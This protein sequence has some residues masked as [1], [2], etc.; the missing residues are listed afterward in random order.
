MRIKLFVINHLCLILTLPCILLCFNHFLFILTF[1]LYLTMLIMDLILKEEIV[2][3]KLV[4]KK[5][6]ISIGL[7]LIYLLMNYEFN[8]I[9][10]ISILCLSHLFLTFPF[11]KKPFF[12]NNNKDKI[13]YFIACLLILPILIRALTITN[14]SI[15]NKLY[16]VFILL[17]YYTTSFIILVKIYNYLAIFYLIL[18]NAYW[19]LILSKETKI[20][21]L[22]LSMFIFNLINF[23]FINISSFFS[24]QY[25]KYFKT[26]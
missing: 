25:K 20:E 14:I 19:L 4:I 15:F 10:S 21:Q 22:L 18:N 2:N 17:I 5:A 23:I 9:A 7:Y 13:T 16:I 24:I 11:L 26:I 1:I 8:I 3:M 6:I 12:Y